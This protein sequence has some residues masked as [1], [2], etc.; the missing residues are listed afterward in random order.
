MPLT[1]PDG[2][3]PAP[4]T[5][6]DR[7]DICRRKLQ[8]ENSLAERERTITILASE[9]QLPGLTADPTMPIRK[10]RVAARRAAPTSARTSAKSKGA[11]RQDGDAVPDDF[12]RDLVWNLRNGVLAVTRDGRVAVMNEVAYRIL[13]LTP[14]TTDI[15]R[16]FIQVL[17]EQ[18]DVS[19][20]VANRSPLP[21]MC[22][23]IRAMAFWPLSCADSSLW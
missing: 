7:L 23:S 14:R 16:P 20:I 5:C 9:P 3:P 18:P 8:K 2:C 17:R 19:R 11:R 21:S 1:V 22:F 4:A 6:L 12:Y 13:G 15:G 10:P